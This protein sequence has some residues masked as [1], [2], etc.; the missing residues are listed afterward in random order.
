MAEL[1]TEEA[2]AKCAFD[3]DDYE[4]AARLF[5]P[6]AD[7]GS[8]YAIHC[9]GWMYAHGHVPVSNHEN[10]IALLQ[11]AARAGD[12]Y[13]ARCLRTDDDCN[14]EKRAWD[15]IEAKEFQSAVSI[16]EPLTERGSIYALITL[17]WIW[18]KGLLGAPDIGKAVSLFEQASRRG[19]GDAMHRLGWLWRQQG[20]LSAARNWF[21]TGAKHGHTPCMFQIARMM[22]RGEGGPAAPM[23]GHAW[24]LRAAEGGHAFAQ[25]DILRQ[26]YRESST[27]IER[28]QLRWQLT[29]LF[30]SIFR[31]AVRNPYSDDFR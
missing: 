16:L 14:D 31:R 1:S 15:A 24:L 27:A 3:A 30:F 26:K 13:V 2:L 21:Q 10:V 28:L 12:A 23:D 22:M 4:G 11:N 29:L 20:D 25:R 5:Q 8:E 6:L 19:D 9:L 18:E 17:G 7:A